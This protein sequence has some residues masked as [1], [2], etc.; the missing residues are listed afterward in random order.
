MVERQH[1]GTQP[2]H[3]EEPDYQNGARNRLT[4]RKGIQR[5]LRTVQKMESG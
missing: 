1:D 3:D 5:E 2:D 4:V